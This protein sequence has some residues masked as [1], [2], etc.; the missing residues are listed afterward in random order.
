MQAPSNDV[1][2]NEPIRPKFEVCKR[3]SELT[4]L[5]PFLNLYFRIQVNRNSSA[6]LNICDILCDIRFFLLWLIMSST[7][8]TCFASKHKCNIYIFE[9]NIQ[10][11]LFS[12]ALFFAEFCVLPFS[13][14]HFCPEFGVPN[15]NFSSQWYTSEHQ[16]CWAS[17]HFTT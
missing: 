14:E 3:I 8:N 1:V 6:Y 7:Y 9:T 5:S 4:Y 11:S 13:P 17:Y 15:T 10:C 2:K 16:P 12:F